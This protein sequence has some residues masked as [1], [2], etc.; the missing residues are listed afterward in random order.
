MGLGS[1]TTEITVP[2]WFEEAG[3]AALARGN[4]V[5]RVGSA[6]WMGPDMAAPSPL[7]QAAFMG[8]GS[9]ADAFGVG[10]GL[11][12]EQLRYG[13][14]G[15]PTDFGGVSGYSAYPIYKEG[16]DRFRTDSPGQADFIDNFFI[17]PETGQYGGN[18]LNFSDYST[19]FDERERQRQ[20]EANI[21]GIGAGPATVNNNYDTRFDY[22]TTTGTMLQPG[23]DLL[24]PAPG[25]GGSTGTML[26]PGDKLLPGDEGFF[27]GGGSDGI[28]N[29]GR[30]GDFFGG[31]GDA[32]GVTD[33]ASPH[34]GR[35]DENGVFVNDPPRSVSGF[36]GLLTDVG[37][38]M[39]GEDKPGNV[40]TRALDI[41][42]DDAKEGDGTVLC[43]AFYDM[44]YMN[45][46]I[47]S[48]DSRYGIKM[49]RSRPTMVEGYRKWASPVANYI[50]RD[51]LP[52]KAL[53]A[54]LWPMVNAWS[55]EMAHTMRPNKYSGNTLGKA[56]MLIG[57]PLS[58]LVGVAFARP[59]LRQEA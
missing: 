28:G 7:Q 45:R 55:Q 24:P 38:S 30:V 57:A 22:G 2:E 26:Q 50:R 37:G 53:R 34:S 10:G 18:D 13:G 44:G 31:I 58:Y 40:V 47:W 43:T 20:H 11:T 46:D 35:W 51:T 56:I 39:S 32:I 25:Y 42:P 15:A 27:T 3:K 19:A 4:L 48:L 36:G 16:A 52:A 49:H 54:A 33:Y 8:T 23:D 9:V 12:Q 21:A 14:M 59:R 1:N 17:D 29:L 5:S 6:P 41:V